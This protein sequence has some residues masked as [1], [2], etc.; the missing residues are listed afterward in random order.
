M[1]VCVCVYVCVCGGGGGGGGGSSWQL[2]VQQIQ[3]CTS[4]EWAFCT[5]INLLGITLL[6]HIIVE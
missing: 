3:Y 2:S 6:T 4:Q 1:C 5:D